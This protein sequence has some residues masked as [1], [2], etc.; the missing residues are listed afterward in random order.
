M[1]RV[2]DE[3]KWMTEALQLARRGQGR[4]EPNPMV[5]AVLVRDGRVVARG[6]HERFGEAHAEVNALADAR[7]RGVDVRGATM[8]VTLEP[9]SHHGKTPPCAEALVAAQVGRVI[10]GTGDPDPR[11]SG[12][13]I[14]CLRAA[15]IAVDVGVCEAEARE[16]VAPFVKRVTTGL[17]WVIVKWAQT[18]DGR[19]ATSTGD[20]K[21]IS[22]EQSRRFVHELRARVDAIVV[23]VGTAIADDPAL[24]ARG[25]EVKRAALRVV[26]DPRNRL[27]RTAKMLHD[28][29]PPV[30]VA[31]RDI[32]FAGGDPEPV[33]R[34]LAQ[35]R[36]ATNVLV[37]GGATL[38]GSLFAHGHVDQVLAF[39]GPKLLGDERA[40][41]A[42]RGLRVERIARATPLLLRAVERFGD[43][44]LLDYRAGAGDN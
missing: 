13:G 8:A 16:L 29:G 11:V 18:L 22:N 25:V 28:A 7:R 2:I 27:P 21:W 15:G 9:C 41:G 30:L 23:G 40:V 12:R 24:T 14:A 38:V 6:L 34:W 5:G 17:P 31:G 10:V 1:A 32:P 3:V 37:E 4:V 20:S 36:G 39:I 26:I 33:L 35:E 42:V 44:V 43:D 19:I